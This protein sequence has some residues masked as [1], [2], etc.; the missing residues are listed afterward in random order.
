MTQDEIRLRAVYLFLACSNALKQCEVRLLPTMPVVTED[1]KRSVGIALRKE[2][3][4]LF[5]YWAT[6]NIWERLST[7]AD[8]KHLNLT[9]L[10]LFTDGFHLP[11]DGSGLRYA[12]LSTTAPEAK[13]LS[14][15]ITH[16]LGQECRPLIAELQGAI[17]SWR[18]AIVK[19]TTDA[20]ELPLDQLTSSVQGWAEH[21]PAEGA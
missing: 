10:R 20:L 3:G 9:L 13:E 1:T 21:M 8:A 18:D 4:L 19:Y 7:E 11:R 2:L 14:E 5:R 16:A 15:R 6:R 12:E 17:L